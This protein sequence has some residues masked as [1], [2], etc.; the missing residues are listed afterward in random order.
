M[1]LKWTQDCSS[2][3]GFGVNAETVTVGKTVLSLKIDE[4]NLDNVDVYIMPD[5]SHPLDFLIGRPWCEAPEI[6]YVK[7]DNTLTYYNTV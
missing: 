2:I 1:G 6:S 7:Y 5:A 4:A 3:T